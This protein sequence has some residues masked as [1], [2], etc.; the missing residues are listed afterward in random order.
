MPFIILWTNGIGKIS[1]SEK[2]QIIFNCS[3]GYPINVRVYNIQCMCRKNTKIVLL[4]YKYKSYYKIKTK[5]ILIETTVKRVHPVDQ[6]NTFTNVTTLNKFK[7]YS[8]LL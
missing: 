7:D 3:I 2:E 5:A 1:I 4:I 6:C 8:T